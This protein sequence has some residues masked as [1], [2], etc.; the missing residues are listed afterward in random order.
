MTLKKLRKRNSKMINGNKHSQSRSFMNNN[1]YF[2][3]ILRNNCFMGSG[4]SKGTKYP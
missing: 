1:K 2:K 4:L 3:E